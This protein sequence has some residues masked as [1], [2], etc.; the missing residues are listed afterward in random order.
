M[1][2]TTA[3]V[4]LR[5]RAVRVAHAIGN[6]EDALTA[7]TAALLHIRTEGGLP[8]DHQAIKAL[9]DAKLANARALEVL[10]STLRRI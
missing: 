10:R 4:E 9:E 1:P 8:L 2:G 6:M 5:A 7:N 3:T